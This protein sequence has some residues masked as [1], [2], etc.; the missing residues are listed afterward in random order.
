ME[1]EEKQKK[2]SWHRFGRVRSASLMGCDSRYK[3]AGKRGKAGGEAD[4][5]S[6]QLANEVEKHKECK[7]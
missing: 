5:D 4:S 7:E 2:N 1:G 6:G 3:N